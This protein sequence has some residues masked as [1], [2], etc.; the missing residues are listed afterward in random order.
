MIDAKAAFE[1]I[2]KSNLESC[3]IMLAISAP[4]LAAEL[5]RLIDAGSDSHALLSVAR[6]YV[7]R[8]YLRE[9]N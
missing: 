8:A 7:K 6:D 3:C 4:D 5:E 2:D 1:M 9:I